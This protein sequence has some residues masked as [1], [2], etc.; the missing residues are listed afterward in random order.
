[1]WGESAAGIDVGL[2]SA[3]KAHYD[4]AIAAC[5]G[6]DSWTSLIELIKKSTA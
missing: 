4:H 1:V 6:A 2:P 3:V 5:H